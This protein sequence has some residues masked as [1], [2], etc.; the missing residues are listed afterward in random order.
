M[1]DLLLNNLSLKDECLYS[2]KSPK[3]IPTA[4]LA[5]VALP[6]LYMPLCFLSAICYHVYVT[7]STVQ[8]LFPS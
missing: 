3:K 6:Q 1:P 4:S 7:N 2:V 5:R 8:P